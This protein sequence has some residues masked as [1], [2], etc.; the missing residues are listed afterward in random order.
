MKIVRNMIRCKKCR[1]VI[2]SCTVYDFK[3]CS[4]G[5]CAVDGGHEYLRRCGNPEDWEELSETQ[6]VDD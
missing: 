5:S 2:E 1:D 6:S 3:F 4:C